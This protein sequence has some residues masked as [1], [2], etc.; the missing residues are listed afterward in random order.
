MTLPN[1]P[2]AIFKDRVLRAAN[3]ARVVV[4]ALRELDTH[5]TEVQKFALEYDIDIGDLDM[6]DVTDEIRSAEELIS[7]LMELAKQY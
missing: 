1:F 3:S 2:K 6:A 4:K 7:R 5:L